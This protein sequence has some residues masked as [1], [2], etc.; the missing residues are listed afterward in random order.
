MQ[1]ERAIR[2]KRS[3]ESELEKLSRH[4]PGQVDQLEMT[5]DELNTKLR[6]S[7]RERVEALHRV[8]TLYHK[9]LRETNRLELEKSQYISKSEASYLR[10]RKSEGELEQAKVFY[11]FLNRKRKTI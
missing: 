9:L 10:L 7:E 6:S 1:M 8:E 4:L 3:A 2:D 5:I 11:L